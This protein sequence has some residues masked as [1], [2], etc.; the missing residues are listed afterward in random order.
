MTR[1]CPQEPPGTTMVWKQARYPGVYLG[2]AITLASIVAI[3]ASLGTFYSKSRPLPGRHPGLGITINHHQYSTR[4]MSI[5]KNR[6]SELDDRNSLAN[7]TFR[8]L[9]I[10][11]VCS[12]FRILIR[13]YGHMYFLY[14][15]S[16]MGLAL[17]RTESGMKQL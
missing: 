5:S 7:L 12:G 8:A 15:L 1:P 14:N 2:L 13:G 11:R 3:G 4:E 10:A 17:R 9:H 16:A 6:S